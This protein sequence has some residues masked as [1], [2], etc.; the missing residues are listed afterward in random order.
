MILEHTIEGKIFHIMFDPI[1]DEMLQ[2]LKE[3]NKIFVEYQGNL[4]PSQIIDE[5]Y[6]NNG[7]LKKRPLMKIICNKTE[8]IANDIDEIKLENVIKGSLVIVNNFSD[9]SKDETITLTTDIAGEY[10]IQI[11][12]WPF[13][14][15]E[16]VV[17]AK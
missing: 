4:S 9:T 8:M 17:T 5:Y 1:P 12:L 11:D 6:V 13:M 7:V 2:L 3:Q 16:K 14:T 15:W 10:K